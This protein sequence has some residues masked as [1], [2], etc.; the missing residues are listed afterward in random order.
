VGIKRGRGRKEPLLFFKHEVD[1]V[2]E[3]Y[4]NIKKRVKS[5]GGKDGN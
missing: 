2:D 5:K 3:E 1:E 4:N